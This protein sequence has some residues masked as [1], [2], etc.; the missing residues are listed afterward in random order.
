MQLT[1]E[2]LEALEKAV[3]RQGKA[4]DYLPSDF[5]T[6]IN[7]SEEAVQLLKTVFG[8]SSRDYITLYPTIG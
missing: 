5:E 1:K 2:H 4:F 7:K 3:A 6:T 8:A